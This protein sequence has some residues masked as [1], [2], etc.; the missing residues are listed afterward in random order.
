MKRNITIRGQGGEITRCEERIKHSPSIN[1]FCQ[2]LKLSWNIGGAVTSRVGWEGLTSPR[3]DV[4]NVNTMLVIRTN[5][6]GQLM[7]K[8]LQGET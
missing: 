3:L 5:H 1:S 7:Q 2:R 4:S 8:D 6:I